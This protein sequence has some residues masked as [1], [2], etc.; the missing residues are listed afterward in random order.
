MAEDAAHGNDLA[1]V[2]KG[3]SEDVVQNKGRDADRGV[4]IG[5]TQGG[6]GVQLLVGEA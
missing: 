1:L 5:E 4:A 3:V 2:M 6:F